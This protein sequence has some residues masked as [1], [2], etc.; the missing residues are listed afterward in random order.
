LIKYSALNKADRRAVFFMGLCLLGLPLLLWSTHSGSSLQG[1]TVGYFHGTVVHAQ[2]G[3]GNTVNLMTTNTETGHYR[4]FIIGGLTRFSDRAALVKGQSIELTYL[5][6]DVL[7]CHVNGIS[8]CAA[9]CSSAASCIEISRSISKNSD[10]TFMFAMFVFACCYAVK[11]WM[12]RSI[13]KAE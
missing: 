11:S 3:R 6:Q 8:L 10:F 7:S 1:K 2:F 4:A 5:G 12:T 13:A 9:Y